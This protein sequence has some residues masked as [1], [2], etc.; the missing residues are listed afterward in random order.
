MAKRTYITKN[1][2]NKNHI[3]ITSTDCPAEPWERMIEAK[4]DTYSPPETYHPSFRKPTKRI[5]EKIKCESPLGFYYEKTVYREVEDTQIRKNIMKS[6]RSIGF[7]FAKRTYTLV[8]CRQY[9]DNHI[10]RT[11]DGTRP[12]EVCAED[13]VMGDHF[14]T[15]LLNLLEKIFDEATG[16]KLTKIG[17]SK[18]TL[19]EFKKDLYLD[20]FGN[21]KGP[22]KQTDEEKVLSHGFDLKE[23]FRR[24]KENGN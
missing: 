13:E 12:W 1:L 23:S 4:G 15:D 7:I 22:R 5:S 2:F 21:V 24:R 14:V 10:I 11:E 18:Q 6:S 9:G 17:N 16:E 3:K 20:M 8:Y 19:E